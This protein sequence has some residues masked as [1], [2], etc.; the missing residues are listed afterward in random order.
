MRRRTA[1]AAIGVMLAA[2]RTMAQARQ[3]RIAILVD[4]TEGAIGASVRLFEERLRELGWVMGKNLVLEVRYSDGV[5]QRLPALAAELLA[6]R[7]DVIV[8]LSTP[9]TIAVLRATSSVPVVFFALGDPVGAGVVQSLARPGANATGQSIMSAEISAKWMQILGELVPGARKL[10]FLGQI[11]NP[12]IAP[13][14]AA[15]QATARAHD[16]GVEHIDAT[17][18]EEVESAFARMKAEKFDAFMVASAPTV[19][20]HHRRIVALAARHRIPGAYARE[21]FTDAGGLLSYAVDRTAQARRT[22]E[23]VHRVLEGANPGDLPVEQ[24]TRVVLTINLATARALGLAVP[25]SLLLR[26]D[27]VIE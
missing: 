4:G 9:A 3:A 6:L 10:A 11:R 25:Q 12:G 24:P 16:I 22:A 1:L 20:R 21:E 5:A 23:Q 27:R 26:A 15:M 19:L 2:P 18:P 7:P 14:Y 8:P 13:V 17:T